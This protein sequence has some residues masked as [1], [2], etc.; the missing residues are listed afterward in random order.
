MSAG[1]DVV[2][3]GG[4]PAGAAA[5]YWLADAGREV[6][7]VE[8]KRYPRAKTCGD[9]LT[10]RAVRELQDMGVTF[11]DAA[12]HR[13]AGLRFAAGSRRQEVTWPTHPDLPPWGAVLRRTDLDAQLA[14]LAA[15][16]GA[17]VRDGTAAEPRLANGRVTAVAVG[18]EELRPR[19]VVV[20]DGSLSRFG[21]R[22]GVARDR[23][24]PLGMAA[25][26]YYRSDRSSDRFLEVDLRATD[27]AGRVVPGY[28]WVFPMGDGSVNVGAITLTTHGRWKGT[29]T[30]SLLDGFAA[31]ARPRWGLTAEATGRRGGM[32]PAGLA[33]GPV[34]GPNWL[35]A[36]DA[37]GTINPFTGE[38]IS[39]ALVTGRM[40]ARHADLA[41]QSATD[42]H[43]EGYAVALQERFGAYYALARGFLTGARLPGAMRP[44]GS[45]ALR[46]PR[47]LEAAVRVML[48]MRLPA[49]PGTSRRGAR[50][51]ERA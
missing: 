3:V 5:A 37:A 25:R 41:L 23:A 34:A 7:L 35:V 17:D 31:A 2:V 40:A 15:A 13:V 1:P 48:D 11:G 33:S 9:G 46:S 21:R 29:N 30:T 47:L 22:L 36:G 4:G 14:S 50:L 49:P 16:R 28:G 18:D 38:G 12:A 32:L 6:V 44:L 39:Y 45:A 19:L 51:G 43:L 8:R 20:A 10:P 24:R 42:R 26:G 27:A